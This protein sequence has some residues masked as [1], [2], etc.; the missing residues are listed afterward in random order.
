MESRSAVTVT[1]RRAMGKRLVT[2]FALTPMLAGFYPAIALTEPSLMPIGL[3]V[4]YLSAVLF[5]IP[6]VLY[7]DRRGVHHW[8]MYVIGGTI[9]SLPAVLLD[10]M[11]TL[12]EPLPPFGPIPIL[13]LLLCGASSG[14]VFWMIGIAGSTSFDLRS[15]FDPTGCTR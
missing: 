12:P 15:M 5:G 1:P 2:G 4:A 11:L 13:G 6:L 8:G 9:C 10:S 14:F 7:F 3:G